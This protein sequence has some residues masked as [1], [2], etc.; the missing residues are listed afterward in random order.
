MNLI[1]FRYSPR[2]V[3]LKY[4]DET[5]SIII[6]PETLRRK[7]AEYQGVKAKV[8]FLT[9][10]T[11]P[12]IIKCINELNKSVEITSI[13]SLS[14][15]DM[16]LVGFLEDFFLKKRSTFVVNTLFK[17]KYY[18]RSVLYGCTEIPQQKFE[19]VTSHEKL[20]GFFEKN[21]LTEAI[22]KARNL[23]GSEEVYKVTKEEISSL[24]KRIYNGN[25]LVEE[26]VE[27][28]QM[29]TCD[30]F[31]VGSNI[32][33]IF[34]NEYEELLLN[35]L[36]EQSGY[37]IRTNHLYWNDIELLKKIFAACKNILEVF[38]IEEQVTPF[39]FEWFYDDQS[40]QFVFCEVGK[41]FGG[42]A[43]PELIQYS[44]GINILEKYWRSIDHSDEVDC[45][46]HMLLMPAVIATSYSP[47]LREGVI[48]KVP[49][50]K[51]FNWTEKTY[52]FVNVGDKMTSANTIV[53]NEFLSIFISKSENEYLNNL[54]RMAY[55]SAQFEYE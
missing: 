27:L 29:L 13:T 39:H 46:E 21:K 44:F 25:Y 10:Y 48:T 17:D 42:G 43:I 45:S 7:Y 41:R 54:R 35:T 6:A 14:E 23:A 8:I 55:L 33:Y 30:G 34:S 5:K 32:Q 22:V 1:L 19:L 53:Q 26:Y 3:E 9:M 31:A 37:I 28:K 50:K 38:T 36:N 49:E 15:E 24:P 4:V 11:L 52:F 47:Y 18:M 20:V 40:K 2:V 12:E 16:E 51:Y